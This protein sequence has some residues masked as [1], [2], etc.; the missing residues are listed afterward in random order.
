[1]R[2]T[3]QAVPVGR[4]SINGTAP[5]IFSRTGEKN[6]VS[7]KTEIPFGLLISNLPLKP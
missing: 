2:V 4:V 6:K 5:G 1:M 3:L 7:E